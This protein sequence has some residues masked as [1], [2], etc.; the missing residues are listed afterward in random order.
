MTDTVLETVEQ[1]RRLADKLEAADQLYKAEMWDK[2]DPACE[3]LHPELMYVVNS[4]L[5]V[6]TL[7]QKP[8]PYGNVMIIASKV[9][10]DGLAAAF[11]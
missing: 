4:L 9:D 2:F 6:V 11:E 7:N 8:T 3:D 10:Q 1:L 5:G